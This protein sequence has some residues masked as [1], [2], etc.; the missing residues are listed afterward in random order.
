MNKLFYSYIVVGGMPEAVQIYVDTHDI[1]R[2]VDY[3]NSILN[4]YRMDISQ[5]A[6]GNE[7]SKFNLFLTV[8]LHS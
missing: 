3:Q 1:A 6:K 5:Y 7:K 4:Q 8:F 2:V